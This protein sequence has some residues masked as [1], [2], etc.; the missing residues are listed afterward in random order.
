MS[1]PQDFS[2][3]AVQKKRGQDESAARIERNLASLSQLVTGNGTPERG[4]IVRLDR[5]ENVVS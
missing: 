4:I 2:I 5:V 3:H 1:E